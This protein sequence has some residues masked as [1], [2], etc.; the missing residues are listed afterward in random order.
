MSADRSGE[1]SDLVRKSNCLIRSQIDW[2]VVQ[3]RATALLV[4]QLGTHREDFEMQRFNVDDLVPPD[5]DS[6]ADIQPKEVR[7][8][9]LD[10]T[11]H[12]AYCDE[13]GQ[14]EYQGYNCFSTCRYDAH[15]GDIETK[16]DSGMKAF[17]LGEAPF[18]TY[19]LKPFMQLTSRYS[20]RIYEL[21]KMSESSGELVV[22]V[23]EFCSLIGCDETSYESFEEFEQQILGPSQAEVENRCDTYCT[24]VVEPTHEAPKQIRFTVHNRGNQDGE[25][26]P[27]ISH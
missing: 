9:L 1:Q 22:S 18:T 10:Q 25:T 11:I 16:F 23:E 12:T 21:I 27:R 8:Q 14:R 15:S 20:M 6:S 3:H 19:R 17:L 5:T 13:S 26:S 24:Y 7:D 2:T 4:A